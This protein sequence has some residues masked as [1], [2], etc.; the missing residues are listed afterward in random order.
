[1]VSDTDESGLSIVPWRSSTLYVIIASSLI[2]VMGVS[3]IS[4][5]LPDLR[6][7]FDVSDA[8]V[9]LV[10]TA[11]TLPGIFLTPFV[12]LAADRIGRRRV[13]VP[14]LFV[15]GIGGAGV[16]LAESFDQVLA[17]RFLQGIGASALVTLA[18]T[19]IGDFYDGGRR[20]AV[21]GLNGSV[22]GTGAALY[23]VIGGALGAIRW[24]APFLFFGIAVAVGLFAAA[25]LREPET[26]RSTDAREYLGRL[27]DVA[28]LP[29]ALAIFLAIFAAFSVF[30][31]AVL[32][33]L[34]LLLSDEFGLSA[35]Q[36]GPLL[37]MVSL[38]SAVVSSQYRRVSEWRSAPELVAIGFVAYG[39]SLFGVWLAPSPAFI[40]ASLLV[41]GVGF[42]VVMP[43]IDTTLVT[44]VS[45]RLR[46]GVM[47]V[48]TSVLRLGQTVGPV[49]FT[50]VAETA[51]S[52]PSRGYRLL[53]FV[54][55][56]VVI[57]AGGTAYL[58]VRR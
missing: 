8:Q 24:S 40:G 43:S 55:G 26:G 34:P 45:G 1:M 38:A 30:Y 49:G 51:F 52:T 17:L 39:T 48:R 10:I 11:Y 20:D 42:G 3:L 33:A 22:I 46:A 47:G 4:P 56:T 7:A 28:L 57:L 50:F 31:G 21:I 41:F 6:A 23:P 36:I 37:A 53:L 27:R 18:V 14:L 58:L 25:V 35:G 15:F 54:S 19:L 13:I 29:S 5:V 12:G 44:L 9:G 32:T 16:S 2:G